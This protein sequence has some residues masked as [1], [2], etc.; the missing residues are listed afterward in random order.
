MTTKQCVDV[1][2]DQVDPMAQVA[3]DIAEADEKIR[4]AR[5]EAAAARRAVGI[6]HRYAAYAVVQWR[7][8]DGAWIPVF[9][10]NLTIPFP[11]VA[12][13]EVLIEQLLHSFHAVGQAYEVR[14]A[15]I[16]LDPAPDR[17]AQALAYIGPTGP[18]KSD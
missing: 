4:R 2:A 13:L 6:A 9:H 16:T 8:T 12:S 5:K 18:S 15:A 3:A 14:A 1:D 11:T 17:S 7:N 10:A